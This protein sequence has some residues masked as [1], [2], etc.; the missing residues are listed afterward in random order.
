M[1]LHAL[2]VV[3]GG[4]QARNAQQVG[5]GFGVAGEHQAVAAVQH[6]VGLHHADQLPVALDFH[7]EYP[8]QVA[9]ARLADGLAHQRPARGD[10][11]LQGKFPRV[12]EAGVV[13]SVRQQ[14]GEE[15]QH[16]GGARQ[17]HRQA[18]GGDAEQA[19]AGLAGHDLVLAVDHQV[20]A[21]ADHGQ[22]AAQNRGITEGNHQ[23]RRSDIDAPCP[24]GN[25]RNQGRD[26]RGVVEKATEG[27]NRGYDAPQ[28]SALGLRAAQQ[29]V[30]QQVDAAGPLNAG[31]DHEHGGHGN[32][33]RVAEAGQQL[34][35]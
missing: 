13:A 33:A 19:E 12:V 10:G 22:C 11:D 32:E 6:L 23:F 4:L 34:A 26:D 15:Q 7:Q 24:A 30:D 16:K 17:R 3:G 29:A 8:A 9:Q 31:G 35:G 1:W 20:G 18:C 25:G 28:G 14:A 21:G 2:A 27:D 5:D